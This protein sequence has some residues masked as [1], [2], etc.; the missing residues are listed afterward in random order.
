M[1]S[2]KKPAWKRAQLVGN[3][4]TGK[5]CVDRVYQ[6]AMTPAP[7]R[8]LMPGQADIPLTEATLKEARI[9]K[10][11]P[12]EHT[13]LESEETSTTPQISTST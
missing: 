3:T 11:A 13:E 7:K 8:T 10:E 1:A 5:E 12:P 9:G 2:Q 4:G 6:E